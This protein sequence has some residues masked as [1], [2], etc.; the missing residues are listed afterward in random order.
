MAWLTDKV[1]LITGAGE[2]I[3]KAVAQ[4]FL[5][6]GARGVVAFDIADDRLAALREA[7][8][9]GVVTIRG[10]VR[11]LDDNRQAVRRAVS[12]FGKLDVFVGNAGIRDARRR[13]ADLT[14]NELVEGF[15]EVF[16]INVKGYLLGAKAAQEELARAK[17]CMIF[18][19]STSSFYVGSGSIYVASKHAVLGL[20][21]A[22]AH[23]LAPDIRVN[24][25]APAGTPT[26][27]A[28][29]QSLTRP[30]APDAPPPSRPGA[31]GGN[32]LGVSVAPEDHAGAFVLLA[33]DQSRF[34]TGAVINSDGGRGVMAA[35]V[36]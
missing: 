20:M 22:L 9:D 33:S 17:G 29:A 32:L 5:E 7:L 13:L 26:A 4:R 18:T 25:V 31:P 11:S 12:R 2:G 35:H 16:A 19:L 27:L 1:A 30:A 36:G 24:G 34:M 15:D 14:E 10:D 21:R 23:E 8:G 6:E 3:G 28:D